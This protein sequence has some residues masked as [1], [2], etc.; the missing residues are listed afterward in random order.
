MQ[1]HHID[2]TA[3]KFILKRSFRYF[4]FF[5]ADFY[6]PFINRLVVSNNLYYYDR[7]GSFRNF[8]LFLILN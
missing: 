8:F 7:K 5:M 6:Y 3:L 2:Q 4:I 1:I